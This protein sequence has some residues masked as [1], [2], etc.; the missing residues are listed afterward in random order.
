[1]KVS[2]AAIAA[3]VLAAAAAARA[4]EGWGTDFEAAKKE[5][6]EKQRPILV[7]FSGSD[8]CGWCK[9][10]DKEVFSTPEFQ[11]Y[12]KESLVL[13]LVDFPMRKEQ[14]KEVAEQN[15]RLQEKYGI[16]GYPTVLLLDSTGKELA[17]TGYRRGG[18]AAYVE[19]LKE[20]LKSGGK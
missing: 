20:L 16:E 1:M 13:L 11:E 3:A 15:K 18:G 14:P 10:L 8:W 19:H 5:A 6:A 12:A 4:G 7:D 17:R 9:K 2:S